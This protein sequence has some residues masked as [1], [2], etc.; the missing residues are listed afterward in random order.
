[1]EVRVCLLLQTILILTID[2]ILQ[3]DDTVG[4]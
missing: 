3:Y 4:P 1:M 2:F